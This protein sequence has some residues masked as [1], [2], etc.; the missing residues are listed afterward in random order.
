[1]IRKDY[2]GHGNTKHRLKR[3]DYKWRTYSENISWG[4][5]SRDSPSAVF[6][7]WMHSRTH[8]SNLLAKKVREVGIGTATGNYKGIKR[9]TM[10]TVDFGR[11]R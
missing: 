10:Y 1:M 5:G 3:Y 8:R 2:F 6:K 11:R 7:G 9:A 4:S